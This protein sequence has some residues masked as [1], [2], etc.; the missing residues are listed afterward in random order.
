MKYESSFLIIKHVLNVAEI[1]VVYVAHAVIQL[2]CL[3]SFS[4]ASS[5]NLGFC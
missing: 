3:A 1:C 5:K 2:Q 4:S